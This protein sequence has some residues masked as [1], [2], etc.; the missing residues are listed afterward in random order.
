MNFRPRLVDP[1]R[2]EQEPLARILAMVHKRIPAALCMHLLNL[3][4]AK[5]ETHIKIILPKNT[6]VIF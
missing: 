1:L 3:R 2:T 5:N 4:E 6:L